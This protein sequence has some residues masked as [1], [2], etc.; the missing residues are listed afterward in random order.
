[1][2]LLQMTVIGEGSPCLYLKPKAF[3]LC[4]PPAPGLVEERGGIEWLGGYLAASQGQCTAIT[5]SL[6]KNAAEKIIANLQY[7]SMCPLIYLLFS[8]YINA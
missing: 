5:V 2:S 7:D 1:M 3:S 4:F 6:K 8:Q